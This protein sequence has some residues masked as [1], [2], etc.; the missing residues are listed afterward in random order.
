MDF[1]DILK[2][3][4]K[5]ILTVLYSYQ[6]YCNTERTLAF[7]TIKLDYGYIPPGPQISTM[8]SFNCLVLTEAISKVLLDVLG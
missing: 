6:T 2:I 7:S 4:S 3:N 1:A 5:R 8:Q